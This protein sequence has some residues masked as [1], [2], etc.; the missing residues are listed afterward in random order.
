MLYIWWRFEFVYSIPVLVV[1]LHDM[2]L[3]V[4]AYAVTGRE[5]KSTTVAA[6]LT[7]L[8]YGLYDTV[9]VFDRI[10]ENVQIMRKSS[11]RA[12]V[13]KS[14][15]E[16]LTR[17]LNTSFVVLLPTAALFFFGGETL[18][19]FAFALLVG[20]AVGVSA[21]ITI[22]TSV[23]VMLKEREPAWR[24]RLDAEER[25]AAE[26]AVQFTDDDSHVDHGPIATKRPEART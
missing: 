1:L 13:N 2:L 9:I 11:F 6:L 14:I 3:S 15:N 26:S 16:V 7:I 22:G 21:S 12:I 5:F 23:L 20:V 8:G 10:R 19:D 24:K 4:G 18:K 25:D 17:S